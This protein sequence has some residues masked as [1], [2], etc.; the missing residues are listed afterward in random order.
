MEVL[1]LIRTSHKTLLLKFRLAY[2]MFHSET[3]K[4]EHHGAH[5]DT[6]PYQ[7]SQGWYFSEGFLYV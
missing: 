7:L 1:T 4:E 5:A 3:S 2:A 6:R